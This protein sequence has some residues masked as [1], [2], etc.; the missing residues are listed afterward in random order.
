MTDQKNAAG[1]TPA[2]QKQMDLTLRLEDIFMPEAKRQREVAF[3]KQAKPGQPVWEHRLRC[4]HYT[5]AEAALQIIRTKHIW[6]R[7]TTSMADYREVQHGYDILC[8]YF[9]VEAKRKIFT[10][11]IDGCFP[12]SAT[13]AINMFDQN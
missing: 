2:Q 3:E 5:S 7:T 10:D 4:G 12:S 8:Q 13:D 11:A 9:R 1:M 6:M